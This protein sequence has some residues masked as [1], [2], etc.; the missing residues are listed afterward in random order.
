MR[1]ARLLAAAAATLALACGRPLLSAQA[2]VERIS[3]TT[4]PISFPDVRARAVTAGLD[5]ALLPSLA[6]ALDP[7]LLASVAAVT[8]LDPLHLSTTVALDYDVGDVP[9]DQKGVTAELALT[10]F[11]VHLSSTAA[12]KPDGLLAMS[13]MLVDPTT[14]A[15]TLVAS[16]AKGAGPTPADVT[17][18][19][20]GVDLMPF[21]AQKKLSARLR[22]AFDPT[23]LPN[24]FVATNELD[25]SASLTVDYTKL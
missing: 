19:V 4:P 8:G 6:A 25:F 22:I 14:S 9:T 18:H 13:V 24:A 5:P 17:F 20:T 12:H 2:E 23:D 21:I 15:T 1:H 7:A 16:Y 3:V 11:T 10:G